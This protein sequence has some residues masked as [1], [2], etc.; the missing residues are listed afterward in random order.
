[1]GASPKTLNQWNISIQGSLTLLDNFDYSLSTQIHSVQV[2]DIDS[3]VCVAENPAGFMERLFTLM[4]H[5]MYSGPL[6]SRI[7]GFH[8]VNLLL[9]I[10]SLP[11]TL[12]MY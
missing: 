6:S 2:S 3:Y 1:M 4:V 9:A 10:Q 11:I 7:K 8:Y 5:G 12:K